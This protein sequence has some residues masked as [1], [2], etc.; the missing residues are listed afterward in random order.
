MRLQ[1]LSPSST[2]KLDPPIRDPIS[3]ADSGGLIGSVSVSGFREV[4]G[5]LSFGPLLHRELGDHAAHDVGD[6]VGMSTKQT[7]V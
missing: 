6:A 7:A 5:P 3:S 2:R 4:T 1:P